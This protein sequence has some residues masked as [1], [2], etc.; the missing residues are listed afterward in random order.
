MARKN[1]VT[2]DESIYNECPDIPTFALLGG[3]WRLPVIWILA[4]Y[5]N[6]RFNELKRRLGD[7]TNIMLTRSLTELEE[8][9][10][11]E[12]IDYGELPY[13]VEYRLT[14]KA[15]ELLPALDIISIWGRELFKDD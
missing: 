4:K 13:R 10:L 1:D 8:Y 12:R 3:K 9:G 11:V 14:Q 5:G 6:V 15:R 7:I 2:G